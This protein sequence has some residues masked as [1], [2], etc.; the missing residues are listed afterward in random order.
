MAWE[1]LV[2]CHSSFLALDCCRSWY[3]LSCLLEGRVLYDA[4]G[5]TELLCP[6]TGPYSGSA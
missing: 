1:L 6:A 5:V 4:D 2:S 3:S